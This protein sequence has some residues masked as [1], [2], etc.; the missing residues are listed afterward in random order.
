MLAPNAEQIEAALDTLHATSPNYPHL[1]DFL[2][3]AQ[4][5][6]LESA[7]GGSVNPDFES[8]FLL[9]LQTAR[10][11]LRGSVKLGIAGIK[12]EDVL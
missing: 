1:S 7:M 12:P 11:V 3:L 10:V 8:G 5:K 6:E 4:L 2:R 9:G